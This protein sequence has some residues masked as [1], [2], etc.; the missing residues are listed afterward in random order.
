MTTEQYSNLPDFVVAIV[1]SFDENKDYYAE[2]SR[3]EN[4]LK[5][6][7]YGCEWGLSGAIDEV[8]LL[9]KETAK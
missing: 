5:L 6:F 2:C 8:F 1:N 4:L 3:I 9:E 7:G